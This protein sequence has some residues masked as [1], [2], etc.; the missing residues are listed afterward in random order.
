MS[1]GALSGSDMTSLL[2]SKLR[3][4]TIQ[5]EGLHLEEHA[6]LPSLDSFLQIKQ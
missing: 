4:A 1:A 5:P 3:E 6:A 2:R